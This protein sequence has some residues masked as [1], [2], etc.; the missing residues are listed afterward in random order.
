MPPWASVT[1][2]TIARPRPELPAFSPPPRTKRSNM[3]GASAGGIPGPSSATSSTTPPSA[4]PRSRRACASRA[5]C[6]GSRSRS[7]CSGEA[8]EL[9]ARAGDDRGS[10]ST[11]I[12]CSPAD[13]L[14]LGRRLDEHRADV[15]RLACA[16][17]ARR[18]RGRAAAGR[19]RG[20]ACAARSA[21]RSRGLLSGSPSSS[22]RSTRGSRARWS[23]ACAAR[24]T[25]R[26]R[27]RAGGERASVSERDASS[28]ASIA[29]SVRASSA[30]SSS[31]RGWGML[32]LGS[33]VYSIS[34]ATSVSSAIGPSRGGRRRGPRAA[35]ARAADHPEAEEEA[36][37]A[38]GRPRR[39]RS[40]ARTRAR[41]AHCRPR[42]AG[43]RS[44]AHLDPVSVG[45][46]RPLRP[47]APKLASRSAR[48]T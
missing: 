26:R 43:E 47:P 27:T 16:P 24:G 12:S 41:P 40:G 45:V 35:R 48:S 1:A 18:R 30:T 22:S 25:R 29:S 9:V 23:A 31:A 5:A 39:R 32:R 44:A 6:G 17:R 46:R 13:R 19:P 4:R 10:A 11:V 15:G 36:H 21:A 8:V 20:G 38:D 33:R 14:E 37:A 34:R 2:R 3:R 42:G 28:A 7:G